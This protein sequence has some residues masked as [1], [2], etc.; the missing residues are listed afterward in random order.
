MSKFYKAYLF[1]I[2]LQITSSGRIDGKLEE[3]VEFSSQET[4]IPSSEVRISTDII[5]CTCV[6]NNTTIT[7]LLAKQ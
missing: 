6:S 1:A 7:T 5:H 3:S 2:V 4:S